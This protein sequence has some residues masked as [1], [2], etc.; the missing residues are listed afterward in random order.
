MKTKSPGGFTLIELMVVAGIMVLV[1]A[2]VVSSTFGMSRA[3]G[4]TA[5]ENV[6]YNTLQLAHQKACTDGKRVVVAFV[7]D[8]DEYGDD[9]LTAIEAVGTVSEEDAGN[10]IQDRCANIAK[11]T[12][13]GKK[14]TGDSKDTVWNLETGAKVKGFRIETKEVPRSIPGTAKDKFSYKVTQLNPK[15]GGSGSFAGWKKGAP[16]GFQII[17]V[18]VLP[19]GFKIGMGAVGASPASSLIVFEPNGSSYRANPSA[20]GMTKAADVA[21]LWIYEEIAKDDKD[22]AIRIKVDKGVIKVV[23][24]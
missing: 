10:Y 5:A 1:T 17:P 21:E 20:N 3:S 7:G 8:Q 2:I 24:R 4:Y 11:Y 18:Q 14:D 23:K 6:V 9:S 19:L 15:S 13:E 22:R 16:Y 12:Q